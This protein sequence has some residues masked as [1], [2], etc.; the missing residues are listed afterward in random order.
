MNSNDLPDP[1]KL[2]LLP[3]HL[4]LI[5]NSK[6]SP[7]VALARGYRTCEV[8]SDLKRL[9]FSDPQ[10]RVPALLI[11]IYGVTGEVVNYQLRPDQ[12]RIV[13]GKPVKY[14]TPF[15]TR[16][17][18]DIP[19]TVLA[20]KAL[21]S[22][23]QPLFITEGIRKVDAGV[24]AGLCT[25]GLLGVWNWRG[26]NEL[27]GK[28]ALPEWE[29]IHLQ[30]R[31]VYI[32]FDS[33]V[34][35]K[36]S[37]ALAMSRLKGFLES[38]GADVQLI[39]LPD[40]P[41]GAKVGLDDYLALGHSVDDLMPHATKELREPP[42]SVADEMCGSYFID[43]GSTYWNAPAKEG[44]VRTLLANF[45][46]KITADIQVDD[47]VERHREYEVE[48]QLGGEK[49]QMSVTA[50]AFA[51]MNWPNE[52]L[53]AS[54]IVQPGF[55]VRDR[56]R[57]AV[58][59]LSTEIEKRVVYSHT[60]WRR[61]PDI[62]WVYLH[63][64]GAIGCE[65]VVAAVSAEGIHLS[66]SLAGMI[67]PAPPTGDELR[68]CIRHT[69]DLLNLGPKRLMVPLLAAVFRAA[70][71]QVDFSLFM[72]GPTGTFKTEMAAIFQSCFGTGFSARNLPGSWSSTANA[73][74]SLLF[75]AKDMLVVID[76]FVPNGSRQDIQR[77]FSSLER[78]LRAQG[79][80][81][82]RARL[83]KDL[84]MQTG[85]PPRGL[86]CV[87]G[88]ELTPRH[89]AL[90]RTLVLEFEKGDITSA[91]LS[92]RQ[93]LC[94]QHTFAKA[95]SGFLKDAAKNLDQLRLNTAA[96]AK[97]LQLSNQVEGRHLRTGS[98]QAELQAG[99]EVFLGFAQS[100]GVIDSAEAKEL[101]DVSAAALNE[102]AGAQ[103]ALHSEVE[104]AQS[105]VRLLLAAISSGHAHLAGPEGGAPAK[106]A[107]ALGWRGRIDGGA[108]LQPMGDCVGWA[109]D[110]GVYLEIDA[111][112]RQAQ[113]MAG[114]NDRIPLQATTLV[115]RMHQRKYLASI[116]AERGRLKVR[117]SFAGKRLDVV[118]LHRE[119]FLGAPQL[120]R[121]SQ[122]PAG[123]RSQGDCGDILW[124]TPPGAPPQSVPED[125]PNS[126]N[127]AGT[128][129]VADG[130]GAVGTNGTPPATAHQDSRET[131]RSATQ[132]ASLASR[133]KPC[134]HCQGLKFW[135]LP[136]ARSWACEIC[137]P[138]RST[139]PDVMRATVG[140]APA[141]TFEL[142]PPR[143]PAATADVRSQE[144]DRG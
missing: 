112:L 42:K 121:S 82:G 64:G 134:S 65:G 90:A 53:G 37:V 131:H 108:G 127:G 89:S 83:G 9:G 52:A 45:A 84:A 109:D 133:R 92:A 86:N 107:V 63:A 94:Q 2:D 33:D 76:D 4:A 32:V 23:V 25:I 115:K 51:G 17:V 31:T 129:Q 96:R 22:P 120:S 136:L 54:A 116:E 26:T 43:Q 78:I 1:P 12:A 140:E 88:E 13:S 58:Q 62:G 111:A 5:Q 72:F 30:G 49:R 61:L 44:V 144:A 48:A 79:N 105:F 66:P 143:G 35:T 87:T 97:E 137:R 36:V 113:L 10:C 135:R 55:S 14:E 125:R 68:D 11:P 126:V 50:N 130:D 81:A 16:M 110:Q 39:Y 27:G 141:T 104:P 67:L 73:L 47:G 15:G 103:N 69:L 138:C 128:A 24:S 106:D 124:D 74:E 8:K 29:S 18:L 85:K 19:P 46:A 95:M 123:E 139:R 6:I 91:A 77:Q 93:A 132:S 118:H 3:H 117:R 114:E 40:G 70:I 102:A 119:L 122:E 20:S 34:M 60:G 71:M 41:D 38:R 100:H 56:F 80:S 142:D 99:F 98:I 101:I 7:E 75:M 59:T 28:T 21:R 57:A